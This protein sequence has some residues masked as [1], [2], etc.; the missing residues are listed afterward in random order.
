MIKANRTAVLCSFALVAALAGCRGGQEEKTGEEVQ[1]PAEPVRV[2]PLTLDA[3]Q[4]P[5]DPLQGIPGSTTA[6]PEQKSKRTPDPAD[7]VRYRD[8]SETAEDG[9][10]EKYRVKVFRSGKP[11]RD[12]SYARF[13]ASGKKL[14]TGQYSDGN[15]T[16]EW[17][18]WTEDGTMTRKAVYKDDWPE[19]ETLYRDDGTK[20]LEIHYRG[21]QRVKQIYYDEQG[22]FSREQTY[23]A[24]SS[25]G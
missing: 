20:E 14:C 15:R 25:D 22:N 11:R 18:W 2:D 7:F 17:T 23:D 13:Y 5:E 4:R 19:R 1:A 21:R 9:E 12:G 8:I 24:A 6:K 16:G 10:T 3:F